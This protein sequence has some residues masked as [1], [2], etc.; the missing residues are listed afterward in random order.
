MRRYLFWLLTLAALALAAQALAQEDAVLSIYYQGDYRFDYEQWPWGDYD[1]THEVSGVILDPEFGWAEGQT[2][3]VGGRMEVRS[4][5]LTAWGYGALLNP[6]DTV[7]MGALYIRS[8]SGSLSPGYYGIDLTD[9]TVMFTFMDD[10]TNFSI[11]PEGADMA[12]F[13]SS[14]EASQKFFGT[15][16]GID[17]TE[18]GDW[19]FRG[20]FSGTMTDPGDLKIITITGG[21]FDIDGWPTSVPEAA[22]LLSSHGV[23]PNPFNPRTTIVLQLGADT[24]LR[25]S[26]H[27]VSGRELAL[28]AEGRQGAGELRLEWDASDAA[29]RVLP[30]GLYLYRIHT[31]TGVSAGKMLLLP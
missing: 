29:G 1:G 10:I 2:E 13:I 25:V 18:V 15:T 24:S 6:D 19:G 26:V 31:T 22:P 9:Y 4:D 3:S 8:A 20:S 30:A 17:V 7:D 5:T 12:E 21:V 11:P 14:M 27:D 23:F 28:L 16:G